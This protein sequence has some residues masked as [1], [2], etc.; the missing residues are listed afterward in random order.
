[1]IIDLNMKKFHLSSQHDGW[2]VFRLGSS[3]AL[4]DPGSSTDMTRYF[5]ALKIESEKIV[6]SDFEDMYDEQRCA[7]CGFSVAAHY[8]TGAFCFYETYPYK[9]LKRC[10][11]CGKPNPK[12]FDYYELKFGKSLE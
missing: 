4:F 5:D 11:I 6:L 9:V 3:R 10:P 7:K 12:F 8:A 1:M 2:N